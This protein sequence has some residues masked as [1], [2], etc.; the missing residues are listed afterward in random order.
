M[1]HFIVQQLQHSQTARPIDHVIASSTSVS[2]NECKGFGIIEIEE[3]EEIGYRRQAKKWVDNLIVTQIT[4]PITHLTR[5]EDMDL[6]IKAQNHQCKN[7]KQPSNQ[8]NHPKNVN[9]YP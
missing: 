1:Y 5:V 3:Y 6:I 2:G 9:P 4:T 8:E 7:Q